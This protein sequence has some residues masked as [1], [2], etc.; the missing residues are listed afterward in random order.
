MSIYSNQRNRQ[1]HTGDVSAATA[2]AG[3]RGSQDNQPNQGESGN[4]TADP[5]F[6]ELDTLHQSATD[7]GPPGR[8][9]Q[10]NNQRIVSQEAN[11]GDNSVEEAR[12]AHDQR[13]E[14]ATGMEHD[15]NGPSREEASPNKALDGMAGTKEAER[16][17][18]LRANQ[19]ADGLSFLV[20][21]DGRAAN[22]AKTASQ[23]GDATEVRASLQNPIGLQMPNHETE[24]SNPQQVQRVDIR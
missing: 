16:A 15:A 24:A 10:M 13:E 7:I 3:R 1:S 12:R 21:D 14:G 22:E 4:K 8:D 11:Q 19:G 17:D 20:F 6:K 5:S 9:G 18:E 2:V 23:G